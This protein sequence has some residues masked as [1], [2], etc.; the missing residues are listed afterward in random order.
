MF[1]VAFPGALVG[2]SPARRASWVMMPIRPWA[3][4]RGSRGPAAAVLRARRLHAPGRLAVPEAPR[5]PPAP[6]QTGY[7]LPAL[8]AQMGQFLGKHIA[9]AND[10]RL[11]DDQGAKKIQVPGP[12]REAVIRVLISVEDSPIP[13]KTSSQGRRSEAWKKPVTVNRKKMGWRSKRCE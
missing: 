4:C 9:E 10:Q 13:R 3:T 2:A 8:L 7:G 12:A 5:F 6:P 1:E 11:E